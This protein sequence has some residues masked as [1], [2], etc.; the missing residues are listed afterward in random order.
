M[1]LFCTLLYFI[2]IYKCAQILWILNPSNSVLVW[3]VFRDSTAI[4]ALQRKMYNR[5][6]CIVNIVYDTTYYVYDVK[7]NKHYFVPSIV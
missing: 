4:F 2:T 5:T 6:Q 7:Y 1:T 3:N